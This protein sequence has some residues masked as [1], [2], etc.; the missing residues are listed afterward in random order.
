MAAGVAAFTVYG[1]WAYSVNVQHGFSTGLSSGLVQGSYSFVLTLVTTLLMEYLL[2]TLSN[3]RRR[4]TLTILATCMVTFSIAY[5]IHWLA[6][7]P[8]IL[9]TITPG[10]LIG[11]IYTTLYVYS[12]NSF[13]QLITTD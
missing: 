5:L 10:F 9:L 2:L 11:I 7:T 1:G 3:F 6:E 4:L 8:E 12:I 13:Q